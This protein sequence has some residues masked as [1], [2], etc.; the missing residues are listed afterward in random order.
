LPLVAA[1]AGI[2]V[3]AAVFLAFNSE[4]AGAARGWAIPA[5]TDIAFALGI[6]A[7]CGDRVPSSLKTFLL[8]LAVFD[9]LGAILIIAAF[10]TDQISWTAK[11]LAVAATA[12]LVS[13]NRLRVTRIAPYFLVGALL[14]VFV[15]KSGIHA[16]LAGVILGLTIPLRAKNSAGESP[17][18]HLEHAL[19]PWIAFLIVP[20]FAFSNAGVDLTGIS[21]AAVADP[22]T[23]GILLG[24]VLG[25][26][27]AVFAV[28]QV[29]I[30]LGWAELPDGAS[31]G[32][33][34]GVSILAG[35]GFTMSL[36]IGTL[37][38]ESSGDAH[39]V[40]VRLGVLGGSLISAVAGYLVL[41]NTLP[42]PEPAE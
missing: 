23:L 26:P 3:P 17:L 36:F 16:T 27:I 7:L 13:F 28:A 42:E 9:D 12:V 29:M 22:V 31:H 5:A 18:E 40:S 21:L 30:R 32:G 20:L 6:L 25:K 37:A 39:G 4:D 41:K 35:I 1:I 19:H 15:L 24:L 34:L 14:W 11:G 10:Y 33:L 38:Y 2:A 8:S